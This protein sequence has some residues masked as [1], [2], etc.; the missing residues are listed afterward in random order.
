M[1][2]R[3]LILAG[4][5]LPAVLILSSVLAQTASR[6]DSVLVGK[7]DK[8]S[9]ELVRIRQEIQL[10]QD[11]M[12]GLDAREDQAKRDHDDI[13]QEIDLIQ[14]LLGE[15]DQRERLLQEQ[16]QELEVSLQ[17]SV[18]AH[19]NGQEALARNLRSMYVRGRYRRLEMAL[20]ADSFSSFM[21]RMKWEAMLTRLGAGMVE[22]L[23]AE[24][25]RV[26]SESKQLE[27]ARA[28]I[29]L[30]REEAGLQTGRLEDLMAEK[31]AVLRDVESERRGVKD[32]LL[33]LSMS[34]QRLNYVL[35]DLEQ[36]RKE[37]AAAEAA[38]QASR[39]AQEQPQGSLVELA[40]QLEWPVRGQILRGFGRSVHPRF[41]TVTLNNG[42]NI[43]AGQ[44]APVAA[45]GSGVVE[46]TDVLP[47]FGQCVILDHEAGYY[48]L[49]AHLDQVFV[50]PG[51][52]IARGQVIA[53]VGKPAPGEPAQ[54][55]FEVRHGKT[56]LDPMDWLK[57]R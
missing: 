43:A 54:L 29:N 10:Q 42:V 46:F 55:Y 14:Q 13:L 3:L 17:R 18:Q 19:R 52:I 47:G 27:V 40:G 22:K 36:Q 53:E 32:R 56:P 25:Q 6:D 30:A 26:Q 34:E 15:L 41:K 57:P 50:S 51:E 7:I 16:S 8:S 37:K 21:T 39:Q 5:I 11:K 45:V 23:R 24:G 48:T 31:M 38:A 35:E 12:A 44:G 49:Y 33:E 28:E 1:A 20:T 2:R 4:T 9:A